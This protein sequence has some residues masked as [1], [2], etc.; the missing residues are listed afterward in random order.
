MHDFQS[1]RRSAIRFWEWRRIVYNLAL[2]PPAVFS[3]IFCVAPSVAT[4]DD[5]ILG[6]EEILFMFVKS[7]IGAN[8]CYTF[9]YVLE[10]L[11]GSDAPASRW[12][13]WG[14]PLALVSGILVAMLLALF[15]GAGI[16][17]LQYGVNPRTGMI[18]R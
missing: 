4:G 16:A 1:Y 5:P 17:M 9:A 18:Q 6:T 10:F 7:A 13:R 3:F 12:L 15:S 11:F 2:I 8:I 14:R